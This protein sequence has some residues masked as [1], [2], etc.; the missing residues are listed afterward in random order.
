MRRRGARNAVEA[1][2]ARRDA[3][4]VLCDKVKAA[5]VAE[6]TAHEAGAGI[7]AE[8][9]DVLGREPPFIFAEDLGHLVERDAP[10]GTPVMHEARAAARRGRE[11][12]AL[13][14]RGG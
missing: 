2:G 10:C 13:V 14:E 12:S 3:R 1:R 8:A 6:R 9:L 11:N 7:A 4:P 5:V